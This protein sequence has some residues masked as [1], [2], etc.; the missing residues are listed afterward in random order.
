MK[1]LIPGQWV[2]ESAVPQL[3]FAHVCVSCQNDILVGPF[4]HC[5]TCHNYD[6]CKYCYNDAKSI[7]DTCKHLLE[8]KSVDGFIT[9]Q[10]HKIRYDNRDVDKL[11]KEGREKRKKEN[12]LLIEIIGHADSCKFTSCTITN[13]LR[14]KQYLRHGRT[15]KIKVIGKCFICHCIWT[16]LYY[17][18]QRC[19]IKSCKI[20]QCLI[21]RKRTLL[22]VE[23]R[24]KMN[25]RYWKE[26]KEGI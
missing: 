14:M 11:M 17:H 10:T 22:L 9:R 24:R 19:L 21:I 8:A 15:C 12:E 2:D 1:P 7:R 13:C 18:A 4:Y 6:L 26:I 16:L 23:A 5:D 20:P 3:P 25:V